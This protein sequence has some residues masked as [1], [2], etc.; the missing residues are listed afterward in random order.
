MKHVTDIRM[1]KRP[2]KRDG[3][4][5]DE[6]G[7]HWLLPRAGFARG[8]PPARGLAGVSHGGGKIR[9]GL[10]RRRDQFVNGKKE[11]T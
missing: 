6:I 4:G 2:T 7:R 3:G 10:R 5:G 8:A 1:I 9:A 11:R